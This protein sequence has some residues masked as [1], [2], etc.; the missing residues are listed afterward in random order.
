MAA[1]CISWVGTEE[2][3]SYRCLFQLTNYGGEG[4]YVITSLIYPNGEYVETLYVG[5]D[6]EDVKAFVI[7]FTS[8]SSPSST[9]YM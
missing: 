5:G 9:K 3:M 4:A 7:D 1:L 6:D 8:F 2:R